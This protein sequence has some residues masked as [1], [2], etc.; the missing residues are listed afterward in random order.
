MPLVRLEKNAIERFSLAPDAAPGGRAP[1]IRGGAALYRGVWGVSVGTALIGGSCLRSWITGRSAWL[2]NRDARVDEAIS[3]LEN[4]TRRGKAYTRRRGFSER[5][6][7]TGTGTYTGT[8]T[9]FTLVMPRSFICRC[10]DPHVKRLR[11]AA[12][13]TNR[14]RPGIIPPYTSRYHSPRYHSPV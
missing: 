9:V 7:Y 5:G 10:R 1:K 3:L 11:G 13:Q 6:N 2:T 12:E 8:C 4:P 14:T